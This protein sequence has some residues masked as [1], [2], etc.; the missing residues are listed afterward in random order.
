MFDII[1]VE[2]KVLSAVV[3][4]LENRSAVVVKILKGE[5]VSIHVWLK[6]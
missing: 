2:V 3:V 4:N 5:L 6:I 1:K